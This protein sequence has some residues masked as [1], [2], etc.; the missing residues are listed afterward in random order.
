MQ[1][2]ESFAYL[3]VQKT[4]SSFLTRLFERQVAE[5]RTRYR[6]HGPLEWFP[7]R[8]RIHVIS[9]RDPVEAYTSLY[10]FGCMGRGA[11]YGS[12][13]RSGNGAL[14]T[15]QPA[16]FGRW[17]EFVLAAAGARYLDPR[18]YRWSGAH[19]CAGIMSYR[20]A[21]L[22][23]PNPV[24]RFRR[25]RTPDE[26]LAVYDRYSVVDE[27]LRLEHLR[28]DLE[29]FVRK[30]EDRIRWRR[31]V[32]KVIAALWREGPRNMSAGMDRAELR[33]AGEEHRAEILAREPLLARRFGYGDT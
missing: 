17:L 16:G 4:G 18:S 13:T 24:L 7:P 33:Q 27:S 10:A 12:I 9:V 5:R 8:G 21:R 22:A 26:F 15:G 29:A 3:D 1:A 14:Y 28:E 6:M 23:V 32:D 19:R 31:P 11:M 30:Y 20:V 25:A 2:Y